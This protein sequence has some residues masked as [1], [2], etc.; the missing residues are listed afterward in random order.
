MLWFD[1]LAFV[2]QLLIIL[3]LLTVLSL[4]TE[5]FTKKRL[6]LRRRKIFAR[7]AAIFLTVITIFFLQGHSLLFKAEGT[8]I[9][10]VDNFKKGLT[11]LVPLLKSDKSFF[12]SNFIFIN[13]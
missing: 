7:Y 9:S 5:H 11:N 3:G 12:D 10:K 8:V 1:K 2:P 4:L 6:T 13:I